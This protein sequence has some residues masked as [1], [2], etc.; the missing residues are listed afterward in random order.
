MGKGYSLKQPSLAG[1]V[2]SPQALGR[3]DQNKYA[4]GVLKALNA[5]VTR[6]G[7]IENRPGTGYCGAVKT[8]ATPVRLVPFISFL[9][10]SYV[11]EVGFDGSTGY[12]RP[13]KNGA[14]IAIGSPAAWSNATTYAAGDLVTHS[15]VK[16]WARIAGINHQPDISPIY[17]Y[18]QSG[19]L[20]ELQVSTVVAASL[21]NFQYVQQ[22]DILTIAHQLFNPI[23]VLHYSD[24]DWAVQT[25]VIS[26]GTAA[27]TNIAGSGTAGVPGDT[28]TFQYAVTAVSDKGGESLQGTS[29]SVIATITNIVRTGSGLVHTVTVT[30]IAHGLSTGDQVLFDG[31]I[32]SPNPN[33]GP[34]AMNGY[35]F[36]IDKVDADHFTVR[37]SNWNIIGG[38][39]SS[40]GT[41]SLIGVG[42]SAVKNPTDTTAITLTW[43]A[44]TGAASYNI[45]RQTGGIFGFVGTTKAPTFQDTGFLPNTANQPPTQEKELF[46]TA[47]DYPAVVGQYQQRLCFANTI[48]SPSTVWMTRIGIYTAFSIGTP[49]L[50]ADY[51]KF[52][53][54]ATPAQPI[55]SLVDLG[56]LIIHTAFSEFQVTGNVYGV[57][58]PLA[59]NVTNTG[60]AGGALVQPVVIGNT[61]LFV[62]Q[63]AT[64]LLDLRYEVQRFTFAGKDLTKF[65]SDLFKGRT[66]TSLAYQKLPHSIVWTVL[67]N[68]TMLGLTYVGEDE[69]YA[70][71]PHTSTNG[72]FEQVA[73]VLEGS[74]W[75]LYAVVRR[76][77]SGATVRY[78]ERFASRDCLDTVLYSDSVFLDCSL[79]YDGRNTGATT[80]TPTTGAGWTLS[81][82]ITLTASAPKFTAG[83]VGNRVVFQQVDATTGL[84]TDQVVFDIVGYTSTTVVTAKPERNV[85]AWAQVALASWGKAVK[86]F[87]GMT[88]LAGQAIGVLADGNEVADPLN[89]ALP[90][91]TV[92]GGGAFALTIPAMVVTAGLPIQ[93][94]VVTLPLENAQGETLQNKRIIVREVTPIFYNSRGGSYGQDEK[95]LNVWKQ[96]NPA[97]GLPIAPFTGPARIPINGSPATTGS[98]WMRHTG[99]TPWS[100]SAVI[101]T[102]EVGD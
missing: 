36:I 51:V 11:L 43:G 9:G 60:S 78:L 100:I 44:V 90:T 31:I 38:T 83:D 34:A 27:P 19:G 102:I 61:D 8:A 65:A 72:A 91:I 62:Q 58:T 2:I 79:T 88:Q 92:D 70:W 75:V 33:S 23:Q 74:T 66:I 45:Y 26:P 4:T 96:P 71:H 29:G 10:T 53:I 82:L 48:N 68:G 52:T 80:M 24:T 13:W 22:N 55:Q 97:S 76:T 95:H 16:Y 35:T 85:P 47:L 18:A 81:D 41:A 54:A 28:H 40:G 17:W 101:V 87:S 84:V 1:G 93:T 99:P 89:A 39:Y 98:V 94:D 20:L 69:L 59:I 15:G 6:Y 50:D 25:F 64:R 57:I 46:A 86:S 5:W 56:K 14:R 7:T 21:A 42:I 12:I 37:N 49:V 73:V 77:V 67:D 32:G 3:T 63:G 30:A